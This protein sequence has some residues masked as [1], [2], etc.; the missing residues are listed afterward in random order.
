M[1]ST[2]ERATINGIEQQDLLEVHQRYAGSHR[3]RFNMAG[4]AAPK[5]D[6]V[7]VGII[8]LGNRGPGH[9]RTLVQIEEVEIKC[10]LTNRSTMIIPTTQ[11]GNPI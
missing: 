1:N 7:R 11:R 10:R 9:L 5:L 2:N 8:G 3:Q 6:T 4:Y